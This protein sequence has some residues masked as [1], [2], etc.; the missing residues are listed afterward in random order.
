[1]KSE[2]LSLKTIINELDFKEDSYDSMRCLKKRR[3]VVA[4]KQINRETTS[5]LQCYRTITIIY[6]KAKYKISKTI[7][8]DYI[9]YDDLEF[10]RVFLRF[11]RVRTE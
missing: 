2:T 4:C 7:K 6:K 9:S 1:M 11:P 5:S 10:P 3:F 8:N